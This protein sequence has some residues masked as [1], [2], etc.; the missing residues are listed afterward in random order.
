MNSPKSAG[1]H[2]PEWSL[3]NIEIK[4]LQREVILTEV[5]SK[6]YKWSLI[7]NKENN[8]E[9]YVC[10]RQLEYV[11]VQRQTDGS[12]IFYHL[13]HKQGGKALALARFLSCKPY[14]PGV[15]WDAEDVDK[16]KSWVT[17]LRRRARVA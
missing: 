10:P 5:L 8:T 9:I 13:N 6:L 12:E 2:D 4:R 16:C 15:S 3:Q 7:Q 1:N 17:E 11:E 14:G